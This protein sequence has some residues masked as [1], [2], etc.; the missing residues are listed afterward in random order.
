VAGLLCIGQDVTARRAMEQE[1]AAHRSHL[2]EQVALRTAELAQAKE[3]AETANLAKSAFL[4]NTSHEIRT[5][6]NAIIGMT[7]L[8]LRSG[9]NDDQALRL[10]KIETAGQHL[11]EILNAVLDLSKIEAGKLSLE[12]T[13]VAVNGVVPTWCPCSMIG[14]WPRHW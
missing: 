4:A 3:A 14:P 1:L 7:H 13:R 12:R 8:L 5:P 11:L 2:E 6:L 9:V 10:D